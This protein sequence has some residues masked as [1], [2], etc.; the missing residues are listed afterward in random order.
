MLFRSIVIEHGRIIFNGDNYSEEW[1]KEAEKRGLPN[2]R[3]TVESIETI[4]EKEHVD[5]LKRHGVLSKQELHARTEI[6]LENYSKTLNI[7]ANVTLNI[8]KRQILPACIQYSSE[9]ASA[10]NELTAAGITPAVQKRELEKTNSLL[11][12]LSS[13]IEI[14]R[15][16]WRERV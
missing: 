12:D 7:E 16:S 6:L 8:A 11:E 3:S 14:G 4:L 15:A 13:A 2:I 1:V 5:L 10:V 9:L